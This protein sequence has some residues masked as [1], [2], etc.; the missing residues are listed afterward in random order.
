M[1][2]KELIASIGVI[3]AAL[4]TYDGATSKT[5]L[6]RAIHEEQRERKRL[7]LFLK[8]EQ[9]VATVVDQVQ[10]PVGFWWFGKP[11]FMSDQYKVPSRHISLERPKVMAD[12]WYDLATFPQP[13]LGIAHV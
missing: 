2:M 5:R 1:S 9:A 6:D 4:I 10:S 12:I 3:V 13:E 11:E 8:A 7:N